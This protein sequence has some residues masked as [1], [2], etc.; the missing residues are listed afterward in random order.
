MPDG[1]PATQRRSGHVQAL[2]DAVWVASALVTALEH[3][4]HPGGGPAAEVLA[5]GGLAGHTPD[6]WALT[7]EVAAEIERQAAP[8]AASI[9]SALGQA[10][11]ICAQAEPGG[12]SRYDE[13]VLLAQGQMSA[14]G[15][16]AMAGFI[17]SVP[18]LTAAFKQHGVFLDIGVGVAAIACAFC[19]AVPGARVI[20][21]D[22]HAAAL[23]LARQ[24]IADKGLETR[25][26]LRLQAVQD[27]REVAVADL[28]HISPP[29]ISSP[30][31]GDG[32][33]RLHQA[34]KPG[35]WLTLSGLI[36]EGTDG[37]IGRWQALN[38]G[39]TAITEQQCAGL[40]RSAGFEPP[41]R[42]ALPPGA[43]VVLACR[44]P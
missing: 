30:V 38:A 6:G 24:A 19:E 32:L 28:A 25:I 17:R 43:P 35:G 22:V 23:A 29:F 3:P 1:M 16:R 34:L 9:R 33:A 4:G 37:A 26:Q 5:W 2:V 14:P 31:L 20:G 41:A 12:W 36:A 42:L 40:L 8:V 10:A 39:G 18:E 27:L 21:L 7:A 11:A 44:R 15:G 13:S